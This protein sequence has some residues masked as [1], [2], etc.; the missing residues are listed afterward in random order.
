MIT[1]DLGVHCPQYIEVLRKCKLNVQLQ[2][3]HE[4]M[5]SLFPLSEQLWT[6][7]VN[8]ELAQVQGPEDVQ[9]IQGLFDRATQ[10][11]LSVGLWCSYLE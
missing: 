4:R 1:C 2:S 11:Y 7:W 6:E 10:D 3:A 8:D 9:R 5:G